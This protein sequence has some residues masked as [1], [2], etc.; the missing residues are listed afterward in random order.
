MNRH[1]VSRSITGVV[2]LLVGAVL[3]LN[4]LQVM[5]VG[6]FVHD[7]WPL[8]IV[9]AGILVLINSWRSWAVAAFLIVLGG[10]YQLRELGTL[11]VEPWTVVWP[12]ILIFIGVSLVFSRS[13]TGKRVTRAERDDVTAILAGSNVKNHSKQFK[14]SNALAIMG[15]AQLDL[16]EA[17]F[18][19]TALVDVFGFWGGVEIIVPEHVVVRNQMSN[20]LAGTEDKTHQTT[21]KN[22]PVLTIT[23]MVIMAGV[24]IRNRPSSE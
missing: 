23:G 22:S 18:D 10:L 14:Q 3:L 19:K 15:G 7:Y 20:I 17:S 8:A 5:N 13:Y 1:D 9:V 16:R 12:L 6:Q 24:T 2:V 4:G 21:D 11:S